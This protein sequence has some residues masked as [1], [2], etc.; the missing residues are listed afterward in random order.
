[1]SAKDSTSTV[2]RSP[3][4]PA[5]TERFRVVIADPISA[6]GLAPLV[7]DSRF[8]VVERLGRK[9]EDLVESMADA[10]AVIV[11]SAT[12]ITREALARANHLRVIGRAGVGVDNID[13]EAA[14]ERGIAVLNAPSGNTV[15]AAE[16]AFALLLALVRQV[17]RADRSM[18]D[19]AWDRKSFGGIELYGKTLGLVG[20]GRIGATVA[21]RARAFGMN[22]VAFDP[23]I[24]AERAESLGIEAVTLDEVLERADVI[25]LH[26]PLTDATR[27]L[28]GESELKRM[29]RGAFL[30]NAARGG[31]VDEAALYRALTEG[32]IAGA[33]L[34][35]FEAEPP[36]PDHPLRSL[37]NV[38]LT[39]HLGAATI[40]AQE[41]VAVEIADAVK[42]ALLV[43]DFSRAVNAPAIGGEAMQRLRPLLDLAERLGRLL[44]V[45]ATGPVRRIDVRYS[46][47]ADQAPRPLTSSTLIGALENIVGKGAVNMVNAIHLAE[48]RGIQI[49]STVL[50]R[51]ADYGEYVEVEAST[52]NGSALVA[53]AL[54]DAAHPRIVR[55]AQFRVDVRPRGTLLVLRN[56]DVPGVIG[57]VGT[58][59]GESGANIAEYHQSRLIQ[60]G[61]ALAAIS[62][63]GRLDERSMAKLRALQEVADVRQVELE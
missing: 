47:A 37:S 13:V 22:V 48:S 27:G 12:R 56:H 41:N 50:G 21:K 28:L 43:G 3:V 6:S 29:K 19:G 31:V 23:F 16:L 55:I 25:S 18:K 58:V 49:G 4:T 32:W 42:A 45:L 8:E 52:P 63:D 44:C 9:G 15:S 2:T 26:V 33:A 1:M 11:R 24:N 20:A 54:L 62:I 60:G 39:P 51:H 14:T 46:G 38:V 5:D 10:D 36:P 35:V 34:D 30:V 40:E 17:P 59:L 7:D 57:K 61:D 53:G